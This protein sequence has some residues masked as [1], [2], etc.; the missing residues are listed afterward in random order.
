MSA[1]VD[2]ILQLNQ[3]VGM[4]KHEKILNGILKA[5]DEGL[6]KKGEAIPSVK[7]MAKNLGFA[8][9]T[10]AKAYSELKKQGVLISRNRQGYFING[11]QN[12]IGGP[13]LLFLYKFD[14]IQK[15]FYDG[16]AMALGDEMRV[17]TFFHHNNLQVFKTF[18]FDNLGKYEAYIVAPILHP[19]AK[20]IL[21]L[22]PSTNLLI[23]DRH[24]DLG[25]NYSYVTQ[26]FEHHIY[27]AL[28]K[29]RDAIT[30]Y[31]ELVIFYRF[32]ADFPF[33]TIKAVRRFVEDYSIPYRIENMYMPESVEKGKAYFTINDS[34]LW[35]LLIDCEKYGLR[36]GRDIGIL[37]EDETPVK[38]IISG[39]ITTIS[40]DFSM[41]AQKAADFV[42]ER[43]PVR[44]IMQGNVYRRTSL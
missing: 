13:I 18:L 21:R 14:A 31:E 15:T 29:L 43:Q 41:M 23:I 6:V 25:T 34:D 39:G 8:P 35:E 16:F 19:E 42:L 2:K 11:Q 10:V 1:I 3:V 40:T 44:E 12:S 4:S 5:I 27:D 24:M 22:I 7:G 20:E 28:V 26:N 9:R 38:K 37:S 32:D 33:G 30:A 36:V 17:D